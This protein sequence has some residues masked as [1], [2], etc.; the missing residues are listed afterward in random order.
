M[1]ERPLVSNYMSR[2][3]VLI[4][5]HPKELALIL[6]L[7][8]KWRYG[9]VVLIMRDGLPQRLKK[10][11]EFDDLDEVIPTNIPG[12]LEKNNI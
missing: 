1:K 10:V 6:S 9:E 3:H 8:K 4:E 5:L 2:Q 11:T 7:R 12:N